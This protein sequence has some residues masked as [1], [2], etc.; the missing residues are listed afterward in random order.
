MHLPKTTVICLLLRC[1]S[2]QRLFCCI[3]IFHSLFSFQQ[4][5][6]LS[7]LLVAQSSYGGTKHPTRQVLSRKNRNGRH[8]R[9]PHLNHQPRLAPFHRLKNCRQC[10]F[11][12]RRKSIKRRSP[13]LKRQN[14]L[15]LKLARIRVQRRGDSPRKFKHKNGKKSRK[16][17]YKNR[18]KKRGKNK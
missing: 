5:H 16:L 2:T 1:V 4:N 11:P 14:H 7:L 3:S 12:G 18:E 17:Y 10:Q 13:L 8:C 6:S 15:P 9:E